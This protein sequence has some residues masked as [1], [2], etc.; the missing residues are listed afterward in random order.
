MLTKEQILQKWYYKNGGLYKQFT[1]G[2]RFG[3]TTAKSGRLGSVSRILCYEHEVVYFIHHDKW[4]QFVKHVDGNPEN[5]HI[6][7]IEVWGDMTS[8]VPWR[9][10]SLRSAYNDIP[11]VYH[12][13]QYADGRQ[14]FQAV[15]KVRNK[16]ISLYCGDDYMKAVAI[17]KE[18]ESRI[19]PNLKYYTEDKLQLIAELSK[20]KNA[21]S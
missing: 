8:L 7:N 13:G 2:V 21:N 16:V 14:R 4:P 18:A 1:T 6:D 11:G 10:R 3:K 5:N 15:I 17:R 19:N 12:I 20:L 9:A